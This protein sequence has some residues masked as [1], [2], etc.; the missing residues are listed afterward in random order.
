MIDAKAHPFKVLWKESPVLVLWNIF[1]K[2]SRIFPVSWS[3]GSYSNSEKK[4]Y[5]GEELTANRRFILQFVSD[6]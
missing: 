2:D 5:T 3:H 4:R 6:R 1:P